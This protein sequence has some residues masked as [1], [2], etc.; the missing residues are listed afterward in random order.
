MNSPKIYQAS[1][2]KNEWRGDTHISA[3]LPDGRV[4]PARPM[5][6]QG[7]SLLKRLRCAWLVFTGKAD[8]IQ[9]EGQP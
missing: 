8:V 9:W 3:G 6:W 5:G 7:I 2:L 4:V 1:Q